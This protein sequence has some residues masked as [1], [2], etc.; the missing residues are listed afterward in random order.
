MLYAFSEQLRVDHSHT[1]RIS[2]GGV[3]R[4]GKGKRGEQEGGT[5]REKG[6]EM[7][8]KEG[9]KRGRKQK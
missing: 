6:K 7:Y 4:R 2:E 3:E 5:K 1:C 8:R 9:R